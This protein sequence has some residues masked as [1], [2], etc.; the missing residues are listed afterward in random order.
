V[1]NIAL[2]NAVFPDTTDHGKF[3]GGSLPAT[4]GKVGIAVEAGTSGNTAVAYYPD[5]ILRFIT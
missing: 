2:G 5:I 4:V 3:E 1:A